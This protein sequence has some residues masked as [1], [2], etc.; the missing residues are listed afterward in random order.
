MA[1]N[2]SDEMRTVA[3]LSAPTN[4]HSIFPRRLSQSCVRLRARRMTALS[5]QTAITSITD[6][7]AVAEGIVVVDDEVTAVN[8]DAEFDPAV[9]RH[10][11][12][13][14]CAGL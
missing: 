6:V 4:L 1:A 7:D 5:W 3:F 10:S 14:C 2:I 11:A 13:P 8:A 9:P 12:R